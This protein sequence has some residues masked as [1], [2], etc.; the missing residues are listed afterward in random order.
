MA[1][2]SGQRVLGGRERLSQRLL[3]RPVVSRLSSL[4]VQ[5][6]VTYAPVA[7]TPAPSSADSEDSRTCGDLLQ[8]WLTQVR[9]HEASLTAGIL[10]ED[11]C[12]GP[13]LFVSASM[14]KTV[15][16]WRLKPVG[17]FATTCFE[18]FSGQVECVVQEAIA[19]LCFCH[20]ASCLCEHVVLERSCFLPYYRLQQPY[21]PYLSH[22]QRLLARLSH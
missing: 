16:A 14:D 9:A 15:A 13:K 3:P 1:L 22:G 12:G 17:L 19:S 21:L 20:G 4:R 10:V 2:G 8:P 18:F 11:V 5:C 6:R 7:V